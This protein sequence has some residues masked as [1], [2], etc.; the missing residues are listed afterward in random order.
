MMRFSEEILYRISNKR[1]RSK[2]ASIE[3]NRKSR[4][5]D[6]A[7]NQYNRYLKRGLSFD[8]K[9]KTILEIGSGHGGLACF[10]ALN[11]AKEVHG[12][13]I[14]EYN[15][16][17]ANEFKQIFAKRLNAK[18][19]PVEFSLQDVK[20]LGFPNSYFDIIIADNVFEHFDDNVAVLNEC[21]RVLKPNGLLIAPS[22]P[23]IYSRNGAHLKKGIA[24]YWVYL[25]FR[26]Q[27]IVNVLRR[28]CE[29]FPVLREVYAGLT[30]N[31]ST[32]RDV[33][34]Y[35]DLNYLTNKKFR[36]QI[37]RTALEIQEFRVTYINRVLG[38]IMQKLVPRR[39]VIHEIL[40]VTSSAIIVKKESKNAN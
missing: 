31:T 23:S 7:W 22:F 26:E 32:I 36:K 3:L 39:F 1:V 28:N 37:N 25:L 29:E 27:T 9:D 15:I 10:Y 20:K 40:S 6:Y 13:D 19:F 30:R 17:I 38:K 24:V 21:E 34:K 14:N 2:I 5:I 16:G 33:R 8:I 11:G 35:Q 18:K 4:G 12:I